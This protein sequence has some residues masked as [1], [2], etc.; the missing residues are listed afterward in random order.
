M[1]KPVIIILLSCLWA[2]N[3]FALKYEF[4]YATENI[5]SGDYNR[6]LSLVVSQK[7]DAVTLIG[8]LS[9]TRISGSDDLSFFLGG[10]NDLSDQLYAYLNLGLSPTARSVALFS[11]EGELGRDLTDILTLVG[12]AKF[13]VYNGYTVYTL[14]PGFNYYFAFPNWL[15]GRYYFARSSDRVV[16]DSWY[17][18]YYRL[19]FDARLRA[20]LGL[21]SGSLASPV[22][23]LLAGSYNSS[24]VLGGLRF[25][26][27]DEA[28]GIFDLS[29]EKRDNGVT[30]NFISF[31]FSFEP[32]EKGGDGET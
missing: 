14:S 25:R 19:F 15:V 30:D 7:N 28:F 1:T 18:K 23:R 11:L 4:D 2:A 6:Y 31:G 17:V 21:G 10:Y 16:Y 22:G 29:S 24:V 32:V 3:A 5:S 20:Y 13:Q 27:S 12:S 8:N 26:F 9:A